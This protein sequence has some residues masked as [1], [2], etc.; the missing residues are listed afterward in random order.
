MTVF[1]WCSPRM[2]ETFSSLGPDCIFFCNR[3]LEKD[4]LWSLV[5]FRF[6]S[7][8]SMILDK[9]PT[10]RTILFCVFIYIFNSL[11]V[12]STSC[13]SSGETNCVNT[14]SC[15]CRWQCRMQVG[16]SLP[17][18]TRHRVT[19][20]RDCIDTI[21][22]SWWW[23]RCAR[24]M[25][26]VKNINKYIEKIVRHVGHL[27]DARSTKYKILEVCFYKTSLSK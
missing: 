3:I 27:H 19:A 2:A 8:W 20:T 25:W 1:I 12:S 9:W 13:S 4:F 6:R 7:C 14:T 11:Q 26:R 18:C 24:N 10:W 5:S 23:A 22:L 15:S 17:T 21:C 16:S